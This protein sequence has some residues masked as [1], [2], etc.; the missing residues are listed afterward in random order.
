MG[1]EPGTEN[2]TNRRS[3]G[4]T[5]DS[6][7][8]QVKKQPEN[9]PKEIEDTAKVDRK[10]EDASTKPDGDKADAPSVL[11]VSLSKEGETEGEREVEEE[12]EGTQ[13]M[14]EDDDE[15]E[16]EEEEDD[17][18][19]DVHEIEQHLLEQEEDDEEKEEEEQEQQ[20]EEEES[21]D[22]PGKGISKDE[23]VRHMEEES[24]NLMLEDDDKMLDYEEN[25]RTD[26]VNGMI[27]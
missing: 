9:E 8:G 12:E 20:E 11:N 17:D 3:Q 19:D 23:Y 2:L 21:F 22:E 1:L 15:K 7:S 18:D 5:R 27:I 13:A 6:S 26:L 10:S 24:I 16:E 25:D 4:R 14:N